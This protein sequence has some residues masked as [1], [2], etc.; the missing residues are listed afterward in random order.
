VHLDLTIVGAG[1]IGGITGAYLARAGHRVRLVDRD[2][3]H[4]EA[5]RGRGLEVAGR[6]TFTVRVPAYL[7]H[8]V[9]GPIT[10]LLLAVKTLHT[11][12]ALEPFVPRLTSDGIVVSMQNGLEGEKIAALVGAERT[13]GAFLTFGGH[14]DRPGRVVYSGPGSLRVGEL[15]GRI[16]PRVL[17][18]ARLLSD[19]HPTEATENIAGFLWGKLILGT[20][21]FA[22]ATVDADVV[23]ILLRA[24]AREV[25]AA[26]ATEAVGVAEA[27]GVRV[28]PV[29]GF[30]PQA[31]RLGPGHDTAAAEAA[32]DAQLAY[33]RRGLA[34]RTGVWRDLAVRRRRTEAGPI[35][36]ALVEAGRR[37]GRPTPRAAALLRI[38]GE[39][40]AGG[41]AMGWENLVEIEAAS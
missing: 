29:D 10:T 2:A 31:V 37:A 39:I 26:L 4:V 11:R 35:L 40:E 33:W 41:R 21:Y 36:G 1:A 25:L 38:I 18:L 8:E 27:L 13:I 9:E 32:W 30:D 34:T 14:Y 23:D 20:I 6:E 15:D 22:T 3:E 17:L 5:I 28:E 12:E 16:T 7:P 24:D 19:F